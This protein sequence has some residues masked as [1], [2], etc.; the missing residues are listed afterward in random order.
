M[1]SSPAIS[2]VI[3]V[4][5]EGPAL[6]RVL[7]ALE[8]QDLEPLE[9]VVVDN[10]SSDGSRAV[11]EQHGAKILQISRPDFTYGRALNMGIRH[12]RGEFVSIL[13]AH[14]LPIGPGFLRSAVAPFCDEKVAAVRCLS[15]TSRNE[16]ENWTQPTMLE[17]PL[18]LETVVSSAPVN[19]AS[20]IRRSVWEQIPYDETL[21]S[22]EDKFWAFQVLKSGYRT[23]NST[24][25][26]LYLRDFGFSDKV[27]ILHRDRVEFFRKTGR[28]WQEP[29]VSMVRLLSNAFYNIPRRAFRASI[30][31]A[32]LY[33]CLKTIPYR[34][35]RKQKAS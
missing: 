32:T 29:P 4:R 18:E 16:M 9:V 2:V 21:A 20:M 13:S 25:V 17:W 35:K 10:E 12:A 3:R 5:N 24:A 30:F 15:V 11:A 31:E 19:C 14:S 6:H 8:A 28:Q 22:V 33:A 27:R 7:S 1:S 34:T 26:Y 23:C